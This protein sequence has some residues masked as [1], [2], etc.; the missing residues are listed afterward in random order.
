L[1]KATRVSRRAV[2]A[3]ISV[4]PV[5]SAAVAETS[6]LSPDANL[7]VLGHEFERVVKLLDD[8][9]WADEG[10]LRKLADIEGKLLSTQAKTMEGLGIK[11]RVACW[12]LLGDLD[13]MNAPTT[14]KRMTLSIV[15]DLIR[16]HYPDLE[17]T[18]ALAQLIAHPD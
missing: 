13:P 18:G 2:V 11:A 7:V 4:T 6:T 12:A 16:I 14:D 3:G 10:S 8:T 1:H 17:K 15:R 9:E 5:V